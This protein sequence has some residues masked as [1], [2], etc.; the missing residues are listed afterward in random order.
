MDK[1]LRTMFD[2]QR[3]AKSE[4]LAKVIAETESRYGNALSDEELEM[5]SAAGDTGTEKFKREQQEK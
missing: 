4:K 2:Y 1:K 3:F 5:V